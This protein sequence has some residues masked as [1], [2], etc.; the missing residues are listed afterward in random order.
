MIE[1]MQ[2]IQVSFGE[3]RIKMQ[4]FR[5]EDGHLGIYFVDT[6]EPHPIN[7]RTEALEEKHWPQPGEIYFLFRN[8]ESARSLLAQVQELVETMEKSEE[9]DDGK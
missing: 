1:N 7:V 2:P 8:I 5:D 6:G 9:G 4:Q 3:G